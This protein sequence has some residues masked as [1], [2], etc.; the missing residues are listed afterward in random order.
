MWCEKEYFRARKWPVQRTRDRKEI[1]VYNRLEDVSVPESS[2][3]EGDG[4]WK[5][6]PPPDQASLWRP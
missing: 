2:V 4:V 1:T 6:G 5:G 3:R